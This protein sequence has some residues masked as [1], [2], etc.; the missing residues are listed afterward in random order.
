MLKVTLIGHLGADAELRS[1]QKGSPLVGFRVAVSQVRFGSDGEREESTEWFR[2]RVMGRQIESA[3]RL[4][5]GTRVLVD[6]RLDISHY[7]SGEGESRTAFDIWAD[8][9]QNLSPRAG[10]EPALPSDRPHTRPDR[11]PASAGRP[12]GQ[13][14]SPVDNGDDLPW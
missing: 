1:T 8:D 3:Q 13:T 6:G 5:K 10:A 2:V 9:V 12:M 14:H 7:Q 11:R 4:A